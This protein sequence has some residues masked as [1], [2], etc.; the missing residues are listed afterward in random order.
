[1]QRHTHLFLWQTSETR[2]NTRLFCFSPSACPSRMQLRMYLFGIPCTRTRLTIRWPC[3]LRFSPTAVNQPLTPRS[4][5][6][7]HVFI[8]FYGFACHGICF[9]HRPFLLLLDF[10]YIFYT[11]FVYFL[12]F[13]TRTALRSPVLWCYAF[14][15]DVLLLP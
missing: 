6:L 7:L 10:F 9:S 5:S 4:C 12:F 14:Y 3:S 1:M 13:T 2:Q 15:Y 8:T 11:L